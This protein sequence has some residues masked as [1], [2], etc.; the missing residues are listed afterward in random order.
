MVGRGN[1]L[2]SSD[3]KPSG[4][5]FLS[6]V[7]LP[8]VWPSPSRAVRSAPAQK[9]RPAPVSTSA[10]ASSSRFW[11][12]AA[13]RSSIIARLMAFIFSGRFNVMTPTSPT[14]SLMRVEYS[15]IH[16]PLSEYALAPLG[17][18]YQSATSAIMRSSVSSL[19]LSMSSASLT[20]APSVR[21]TASLSSRS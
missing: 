20:S 17:R 21:S 19:N 7:S 14:R 13:S 11:R 15:I 3:G 1:S 5:P 9:P 4:I 16:L 6:S 18:K 2:S 12:I 8:G 10:R